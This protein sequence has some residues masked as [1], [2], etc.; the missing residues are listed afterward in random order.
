MLIRELADP[1]VNKTTVGR[2]AS[3]LLHL[4]HQNGEALWQNFLL[5]GTVLVKDTT[6]L[7]QEICDLT[8]LSAEVVGHADIVSEEAGDICGSQD[9]P[10]LPIAT[11]DGDDELEIGPAGAATEHCLGCGRSMP[12]DSGYVFCARCG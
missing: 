10:D 6:G 5:D 11:V 1:R 3:E 9:R 8:G 4:K 12:A 2:K 7:P